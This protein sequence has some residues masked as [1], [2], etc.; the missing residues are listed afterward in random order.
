MKNKKVLV[1]ICVVGGIIFLAQGYLFYFADCQIVKTFYTITH[2]PARCI[3]IPP[4]E[5]PAEPA[6]VVVE[7]LPEAAQKEK[8]TFYVLKVVG[9]AEQ[10]KQP[11]IWKDIGG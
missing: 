4:T 8:K 5:L 7:K 11:V 2:T 3:I 1:L 10:Q 6:P 9:L